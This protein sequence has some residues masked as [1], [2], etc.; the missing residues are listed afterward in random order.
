MVDYLRTH[1]VGPCEGDHEV[2]EER[3]HLR[4][5]TGILYP[6]PEDFASA[7][8]A[9]EGDDDDLVDETSG[10]LTDEDD[11]DPVT[12]SGQNRPSSMGVSFVTSEWAPVEIE[13]EL[14]RYHSVEGLTEDSDEEWHREQVSLTGPDAIVLSPGL[15]GSSPNRRDIME[16]AA[17]V[18]ARW[19]RYGEGAIVTVVMVNRRVLRPRKAVDA[20]D[21]LFQVSLGCRPTAGVLSPYPGRPHTSDNSEVQ[22]LELLYRNVGVYAVGHGAAADWDRDA[23]VPTRVGTTFLP[24]HVVPDVSF[25]VPG[26]QTVLRLAYLEHLAEEPDAAIAALEAF[27]D[28]YADWL[29]RTRTEVVMRLAPE[30]SEV[31]GRL[32][33]RA[34]TATERMRG[35]IRLLSESAV[36]RQAFSMTNRVMLMQM[37][38]GRAELGGGLHPVAE[39]PRDVRPDYAGVEASWRPFQLGF[40][41]LTLVGVAEDHSERDLVDLIWFPTG[42]GKTEAYLGLAAFTILH[43]RLTRG[44]DGAGTTVLTRYTLRLLTAQQFQRAA[45]MILACELLRRRHPDELGSRS[46]SIGMWVGGANTPNKYGEARLLLDKLRNGEEVSMGFQVEAC[47][48]CG[49]RVVPE[50]DSPDQQWGI[51]ASNSAFRVRCLNRSCPFNDVIPLSTVDDDLYRYPPTMLVGTVDKLAR[52]VWEPRAGVFFGTGADP[53]P[54]LLIQDEFHLISGPLGTIVGL[55]EAALDVLMARNGVRPK[56]VAATATIRGA[57]EQVQGVFGRGVSLFPPSGVDADDSYFVR[58]RKGGQGRAYVGVMPQG[59]TPLTALVH[60]AAAQLQAAYDLDLTSEA[61]DG[62]WTL[63][64]YHNSLREL[65]KTITLAHDDI[66]ARMDLIARAQ[67]RR[68]ELDDHS[69]VELTSNISAVRI[70]RVLDRLALPEGDSDAVSL[71]ASTNMISVGVDVSRLGMMTMVGQPKTTAEYIQATSRV[72]RDRTRP[73]L[74]VT[75]YSPSKPRDRSHYE[76][77]VPYH[78]MLYRAVEPTSVT[79]FSVSARTRALH[80]DLVLLV[81]HALGLS[82]EDA[83][84]DFDEQDPTLKAVIEDFLERARCA[85]PTEADR[86][87]V[88]LEQLVQDWSQRVRDARDKGGLRYRSSGRAQPQPGLLRRYA[89]AGEGWPTLDSMRSVDVDVRVRVT[90]VRR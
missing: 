45:R 78:S 79:P 5:L 1:L 76:S 64:A 77:F 49:T 10:Q 55:Y 46:I 88:H 67:D 25:E 30:L 74:V 32:L 51:H 68:R 63:V 18:E 28:G 21:C 13:V 87:R 41:L 15:P 48:W 7:G 23:V 60:L 89:D 86:V 52:A 66:P 14:G 4:Y 31:A 90:G 80:A 35:G 37:V 38:H 6:I 27:V 11:E 3:P 82:A 62:Y 22:E 85:D 71:L 36:V 61:R 9:R 47:P 8:G 70:P 24:T 73:G 44:D 72:G 65:G 26:D 75:L 59:H 19:R 84:A 56:I 40:L 50:P 54:S 69:I 39:A 17:S 12:L 58:V 34:D 81:R 53:G 57:N 83:A 2:L 20:A 42:G 16:G 33:A 29:D 43:R